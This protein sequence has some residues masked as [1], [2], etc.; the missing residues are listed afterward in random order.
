MIIT[1]TLCPCKWYAF[2]KAVWGA[3][4]LSN[5]QWWVSYVR[6]LKHLSHPSISTGTASKVV[7]LQED[8][9]QYCTLSYYLQIQFFLRLMNLNVDAITWICSEAKTKFSATSMHLFRQFCRELSMAQEMVASAAWTAI[10]L[11]FVLNS[12][13]SVNNTHGAKRSY[14]GLLFLS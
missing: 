8:N 2:R 6:N 13:F 1:C 11:S 14:V 4:P 5:G 10:W 3:V 7:S 12:S 9:S